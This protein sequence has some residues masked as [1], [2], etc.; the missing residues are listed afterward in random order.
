M[1]KA[2]MEKV[3]AL[4]EQNHR[5]FKLKY[6]SARRAGVEQ[7][8]R[9]REGPQTPLRRM[10]DAG[11]DGADG[12]PDPYEMLMARLLECMTP[13]FVEQ[14][15]NT[16]KVALLNCPWRLLMFIEESA[17]NVKD[18]VATS[19]DTTTPAGRV[20]AKGYEIMLE[21]EVRAFCR[22]NDA[23]RPDQKH[24]KAAFA[25]AAQGR[26]A[27]QGAEGYRGKQ[28][29]PRGTESNSPE[30]SKSKRLKITPKIGH[31]YQLTALPAE[32]VA[33]AEQLV[34]SVSAEE[35][36]LRE[37]Q[38]RPWVRQAMEWCVSQGVLNQTDN[39]GVLGK[40]GC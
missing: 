2:Y 14:L 28:P 34:R 7:R 31:A 24:G 32:L 25:P 1:C 37:V 30:P 21:A 27:A 9:E 23:L 39:A 5:V 40:V 6:L 20:Q 3:R 10:S 22:E 38:T 26:C 29:A 8:A 18:L 33:S 19:F 16:T 17:M 35:Q 11:L 4:R 12:A 36:V 13:D 15:K